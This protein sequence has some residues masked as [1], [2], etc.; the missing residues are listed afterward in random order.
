MARQA[1][2]MAWLAVAQAEQVAK[3]GPRKQARSHV[4]NE[5][6]NHERRQPP[7][8][9]VEQNYMLL[10]GRL[11]SADARTDDDTDFVAVFLVEVEAGIKQGLMAGIDAKL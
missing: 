2:P 6:R 7:G 11:Q 5:H 10:G 1:S 8:P 9:A 4:A 3:F